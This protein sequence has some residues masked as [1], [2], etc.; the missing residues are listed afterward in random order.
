MPN[1]LTAQIILPQYTQVHCTASTTLWP[2]RLSNQ[3]QNKDKAIDKAN[4]TTAKIMSCF[5][6]LPLGTVKLADKS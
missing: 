5:S 1:V 4:T 2:C 6:T 3:P